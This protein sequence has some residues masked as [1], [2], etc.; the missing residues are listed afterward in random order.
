MELAEVL[1]RKL[2][3]DPTFNYKLDRKSRRYY[4]PDQLI[5]YFEPGTSLA[6]MKGWVDSYARGAADRKIIVHVKT[7][8]GFDNG[9]CIVS[10]ENIYALIGPSKPPTPPPP[11]PVIREIFD[12]LR[13][14]TVLVDDKL[15]FVVIPDSQL[16]TSLARVLRE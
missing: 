10:G 8:V 4:I 2:R 13:P 3:S 12:Y 5:F 15:V 11:P 16:Q 7:L 14:G 6:D 9:V 1:K